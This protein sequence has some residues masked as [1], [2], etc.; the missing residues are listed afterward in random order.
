MFSFNPKYFYL[1]IVLFFVEV[2]IG[3]WIHDSVI[4]PFGGDVLVVI[5][6]YCLIRSFLRI[7]TTV[8]ITSVFVFACIIE[9]L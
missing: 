3:V 4:R 1:S 2:F 7:Q 9:G 6:I 5:L 8:A